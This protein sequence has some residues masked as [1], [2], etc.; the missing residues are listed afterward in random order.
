MMTAHRDIWA[1][2]VLTRRFGSKQDAERY[3]SILAPVRERLLDSAALADHE[4]LLDVGCG[5]GFVGFGA[6]TRTPTA[7][8]IFSDISQELLDRVREVASDAGVADQCRLL[9]APVEDLSAVQ[10]GSVDA[11]IMRS[12]LIYVEAK[13]QAIRECYRVLKPGGRLAAFEPVNG[14]RYPE[15]PNLLWGYDVTP[16]TDLSRR[17]KAVYQRIQDPSRDPMF[18]FDER[19]LLAHAEKAGFAEV[20]VDARFESKWEE[21][22]LDWDTLISAAGNPRIPTLA[23]AMEQALT[24]D[25]RAV[26]IAHLRPLVETQPRKVETEHVYLWGTK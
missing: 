19:S 25:E 23:E 24:L 18:D 20:H 5:D 22:L 6:L 11:V 3:L 14:F 2:W 13:E 9:K 15:P 16:V 10:T 26:F 17:I 8:V 1:D 21:S 7:R 12:V 4:T